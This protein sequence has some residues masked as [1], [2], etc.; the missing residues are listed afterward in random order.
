M[1]P[2]IILVIVLIPTLIAALLFAIS[3]MIK[4]NPTLLTELQGCLI[5]ANVI[6]GIILLIPLA[7]GLIILVTSLWGKIREHKE[8]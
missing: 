6:S 7:I 1:I 2:A 3:W 5:P 8:K 4:Y